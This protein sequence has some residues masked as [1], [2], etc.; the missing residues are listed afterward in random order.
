MCFLLDL[1]WN[2]DT[3]K[4]VIADACKSCLSLSVLTLP[5]RVNPAYAC[6]ENVGVKSIHDV[7]AV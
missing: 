4:G 2:G 3:N 5:K 6:K 7:S 1:Q